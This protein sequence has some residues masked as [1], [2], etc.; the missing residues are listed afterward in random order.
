M[1]GYQGPATERDRLALQTIAVL[2]RKRDPRRL[3]SALAGL[4]RELADARRRIRRLESEVAQLRHQL[5]KTGPP[6]I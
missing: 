3:G 6:L 5:H 1:S 4:A 2:D